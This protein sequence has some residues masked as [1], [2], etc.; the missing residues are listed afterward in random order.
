MKKLILLALSICLSGALFADSKDKGSSLSAATV[1]NE[2][3]EAVVPISEIPNVAGP[4]L[5]VVG[6]STLSAFNDNYYYPRYGYG[7]KLQNYLDTNRITVF[8]LAMSG[9]SS[10]SFLKEKNYKT[11]TDN[12]RKGDFLIIGF[13]HN[14][15]KAEKSR[16][17]DANGSKDEN[18][19]FKNVLYENYVKLA[20]DRKATPILC[21]PI[22][23]RVE[24]SSYSGSA[25]HITS[26]SEGFKGGNYPKAILELGEETGVLVVDLTK[27]TKERYEGLTAKQTAKFHAQKMKQADTI[28]NTHLN[29]YGAALVAY[30]VISAVKN[31]SCP[32]AAFVLD[33]IQ[34]P[35]E[36]ILVKN[37]H[38]ARPP[39]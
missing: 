23:R 35:N 11:L 32:L 17:S 30:D 24:N 13:G 19:S 12:L 8:N 4:R 16:Y 22:V 31:S 33:E 7:T 5:F 38:Y 9:R 21:T 20:L 6:D 39:R 1:A 10:K 28:D 37:K 15:E 2:K 27:I 18:G 26:D 34:A 29:M 3:V 36:K 14:D 25:V